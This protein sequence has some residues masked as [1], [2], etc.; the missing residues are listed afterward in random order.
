M[1]HDGTGVVAVLL[2]DTDAHAITGCRAGYENHSAFVA[3]DGVR[4][5]GQRRDVEHESAGLVGAV[6]GQSGRLSWRA[7]ARPREAPAGFWW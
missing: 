6:M 1:H 3:P 2:D 5:I 7:R 4:P